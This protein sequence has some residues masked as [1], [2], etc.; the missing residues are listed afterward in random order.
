MIMRCQR[1]ECAGHE[2]AALSASFS[3]SAGSG[4]SSP[5]ADASLDFEPAVT[6]VAPEISFQHVPRHDFSPSTERKLF[7]DAAE[8][9]LPLDE[10]DPGD[11]VRRAL[12][13]SLSNICPMR[14]ASTAAF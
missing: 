2:I 11:R 4:G 12:L 5:P 8:P 10:H 7:S 13:G 14:R 9:A 1:G 6:C 3:A